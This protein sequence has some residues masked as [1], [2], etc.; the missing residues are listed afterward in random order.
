MHDKKSNDVIQLL[1][2]L[3]KFDCFTTNVTHQMSLKIAQKS[4]SS[5]YVTNH[6]FH[7][8]VKNLIRK[9]ATWWL[10]AT[11]YMYKLIYMQVPFGWKPIL[12]FYP[13]KSINKATGHFASE[14]DWIFPC[15]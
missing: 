8:L 4:H 13:P 10:V 2:L 7:E 1:S 15:G 3:H 6:E 12:A 14:I 5:N 9:N 11:L